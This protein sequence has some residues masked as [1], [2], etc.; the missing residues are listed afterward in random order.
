MT[1]VHDLLQYEINKFVDASYFLA[2]C[3][4]F[5][6][7]RSLPPLFDEIVLEFDNSLVGEE[8]YSL[9]VKLCNEA[10][11]YVIEASNSLSSS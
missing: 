10:K 7:G 11:R 8:P 2:C 9:I 4:E 5:L 6:A 3:P 1:A